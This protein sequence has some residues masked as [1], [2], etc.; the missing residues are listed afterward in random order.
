[1]VRSRRSAIRARSSVLTIPEV[2]P[3]RADGAR[4]KARGSALG[5]GRRDLVEVD[6][7]AP[8]LHGHGVLA[9]A[10]AVEGVGDRLVARVHEGAG[11]AVDLHRTAGVVG[12]E[13]PEGA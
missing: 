12:V 11:L 4:P 9:Q 8:T 5:R 3:I 7:E 10:G 13:G 2:Y 1:S 6:V